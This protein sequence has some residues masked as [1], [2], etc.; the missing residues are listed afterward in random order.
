MKQTIFATIRSLFGLF[1]FMF[2]YLLAV[3]AAF[4][5]L[6][7]AAVYLQSQYEEL[8]VMTRLM[9]G[10][11]LLVSVMASLIHLVHS[12]GLTAIPARPDHQTRP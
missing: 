11:V 2:W 10:V 8:Q 1:S 9:I 4:L 6:P 12:R 3:A 7:E 5:V